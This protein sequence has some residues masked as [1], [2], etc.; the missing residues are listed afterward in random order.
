MILVSYMI[1]VKRMSL[2]FS[3]IFGKVFFRE[4]HLKERL[5]GSFAMLVGVIL[6]LL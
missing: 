6:I 2:L 3:V 1:S 4:E 5:L